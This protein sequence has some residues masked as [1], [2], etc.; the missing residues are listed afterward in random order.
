MLIWAAMVDLTEHLERARR[1]R[2][3]KA[4]PEQKKAAASHA[5]RAYWAKLSPSSARPR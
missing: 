5:G 4:T 3:D 2:W 1:A